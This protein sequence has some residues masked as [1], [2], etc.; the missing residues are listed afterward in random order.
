V[1]FIDRRVVVIA[2][3]AEG[4]ARAAR[5]EASITF[6]LNIYQQ[7]VALLIRDAHVSSKRGW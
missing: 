5:A 2:G 4:V 6:K 1:I 7:H 3:A